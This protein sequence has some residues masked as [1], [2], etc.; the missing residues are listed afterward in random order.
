M[1]IH[2]HYDS[3]VLIVEM[4]YHTY[5]RWKVKKLELIII[6]YYIILLD[7]NNFNYL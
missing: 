4:Y 6:I 3:I 5:I 7:K 2:F 1:Y